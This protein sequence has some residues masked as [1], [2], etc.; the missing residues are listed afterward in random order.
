MAALLMAFALGKTVQL[1]TEGVDDT[2]AG[3]VCRIIEV[4][5]LGE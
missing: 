2:N 5:V 3:H 4:T 1:V